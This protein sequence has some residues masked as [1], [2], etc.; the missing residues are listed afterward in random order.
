MAG[1]PKSIDSLNRRDVLKYG[2]YSGLAAGLSPASF[3][4][5]S[6]SAATAKRPNIIFILIDTLRADRMGLYGY[7]RN[8]TP[9]IDAIADEA[10]IFDNAIAPAPWTQPSMASIFC[11]RFPSVHKVTN[12]MLAYNMRW[13]KA[14][15]MSVFGDSFV[16]IAEML[17]KQGYDTA[18]FVGNFLVSKYY[19]FGQGFDFY[20]DMN[21]RN[22]PQG[23]TSGDVLNRHLLQWLGRRES[24]KPLF[25]YIHYMDAHGP[26]YARP[27]F[28]QPFFKQVAQMQNKRKLSAPEKGRLGYLA[29]G[30]AAPIIARYKELT[31]YQ[32]FWSAFYDAGVREQDQHIS[33]LIVGLKNM[34]LWDDS[35]IALAADHGEELSEHGL[36][37]HGK[38]LYQTELHVPFILRWPGRL[39]SKRIVPTVQLIDLM[40][41][42]I[43]QLQLEPVSGM[44][45]RSLAADI[46]GKDSGKPVSTFSEAVKFGPNTIAVSQG[47]WKLIAKQG[48][49]TSELYNIADDPYE[50]K[51]LFQQNSIKVK[52]LGMILTDQIT[53]NKNLAS[54]TIPE[55]I[56]ITPQEYERLK[57]L[58][59]VK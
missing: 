38:T 39:S 5:G 21:Y 43:E 17:G 59:Y 33:D 53:I 18:G 31:D 10:A 26:Y 2:L 9:A 54:K 20:S 7:Q 1:S 27:E 3:L 15:R 44:Q 45:G 30:K 48:R 55:Q 56:Q 19:G 50:Q 29:T 6:G 13:G 35:Y 12:F 28:Y 47:G 42:L 52:Q 8:T 41:T 32:E 11:S 34:D 46:A 24:Q 37:S 51:N 14:K 57:S 49:K 25:L 16:T 58:G 36:W 4:P 40:P 22:Q 23:A